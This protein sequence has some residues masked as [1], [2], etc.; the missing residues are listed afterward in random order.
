MGPIGVQAHLAPHLPGHEVVPVQY[1]GIDST[2]LQTP[3]SAAPW[4]SASILPITWMYC[5]LM[6][7][8]GLKQASEYAILNANYMAARLRQHY[9]VLYTN[10]NGLNA[11]EFIVDIRPIEEA[12]G[13]GPEDIAK[14]LQDFGFHAPTMQWPVTGTL[15][16]EPTESESKEELDRYCDALIEIRAEIREIENGEVDRE[17]NLLKNA[18][19]TMAEVTDAEWNRP[20]DRQRAVFPAPWLSEYKSW[21]TIG[22][23]DNVH[24]DRNLICTCPPVSA[25]EVGEEDQ[26]GITA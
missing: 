14:R 16:I 22:R 18:P 7:A 17:N 3:V 4:G 10:G 2:G 1:D 5:R 25:F 9:D 11:H 15:M 19:H 23:V 6:G 24:G 20:Y 12:T 13:V 26:Q 21:P 8:E